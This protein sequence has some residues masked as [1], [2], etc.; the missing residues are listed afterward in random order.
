MYLIEFKYDAERKTEQT[1]KRRGFPYPKVGFQ[2][3]TRLSFEDRP[4]RFEWTGGGI[5]VP[6]WFTIGKPESG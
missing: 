3:T 5:A 4:G 6:S 1:S 2:Q